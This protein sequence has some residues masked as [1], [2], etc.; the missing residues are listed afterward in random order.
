MDVEG[1]NS[2]TDK[3]ARKRQ[4]QKQGEV[5]EWDGGREGVCGGD[6]DRKGERIETS[7][8]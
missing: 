3:E 5:K 7:E 2:D 6:G 1:V 8:G 4:K